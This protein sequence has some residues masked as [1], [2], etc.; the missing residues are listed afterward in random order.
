MSHLTGTSPGARAGA[1]LVVL[2]A[3]VTCNGRPAPA[4]L[5]PRA[6]PSEVDVSVF[7]VGDAGEP[8]NGFEPVL[9]ALRQE[10]AKD[11]ARSLVVYLGD[12][13]YPNGLPDSTHVRY[14]EYV[15]RLDEQVAVV[16]ETGARG[17]FVPGNHDWGS[18][19]AGIMRQQRFVEE[20][21]DGR[22]WFLPR[23]GCPGPHVRDLG[24]SVRLVAL[25]TQWWFHDDPKPG[26]PGASC[27]NSSGG[28][29]VDSIRAVLGHAGERRTIVVAHHPL[30]SGGPHGGHFD[31]TWHV[32]PLRKVS[33][34]LWIPLPV[35]G[36]A[37]PIS[38]KLGIN[39]QDL[40]SSV[41]RTLRDSLRSAFAERP[42]LIY[43]A[44]HEHN[45]QVIRD[46]AG[47]YLVVSGAGIFDHT[48]PVSWLDGTQF[49]A[50]AAGFVRLDVLR[51]G[52][53]R[54]AV[55]VADENGKGGEAFSMWIDREEG[56]SRP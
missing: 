16:R 40:T 50:S 56:P 17:V 31:W 23:P 7:L 19:L 1:P 26:A 36:S 8:A 6:S 2:A 53:A 52:R 55:F 41:Y 25:D 39:E 51:S 9:A 48:N 49:A 15:R 12:N 27:S 38:R 34:W 22:I 4:P 47:S 5:A 13:L 32:F 20:R 28:A 24:H 54:L 18:G 46:A 10:V 33:R 45:L 43:A 37:Y 3:L 11:T 42:P 44:G 35:I 30:E 29:V 21:G 14:A